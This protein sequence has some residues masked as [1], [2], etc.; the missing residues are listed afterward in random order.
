VAERTVSR[1]F[2][3]PLLAVVAAVFLWSGIAPRDRFTW[4][5]E[6]LP[7]LVAA[8]LLA[9][10][11]RRFRLTPLAYTL[12]AG[13]AII[14]MVGGH[15]T[16]AQVPLFNWLRDA[17]GLTRNHFDRV[18]H[19]AQGFVP[20]I[21]A[22]EVLLRRTPLRPGG[23]LF[24]IVTAICLSISALYELFEW[25]VAETTGTAADAFL[26]TQGDFWDTQKDMMMCLIGA[27]FALALLSRAHDR[28]LARLAGSISPVVEKS[29]SA[30]AGS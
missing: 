27:V 8:P 25:G 10:I 20:A 1:G 2:E 28:T 3:L 21:V 30:A 18:G 22:R 29:K 19:F 17:L 14:L 6:V 9:L 13:H 11:W 4:F 23:W 24:T 12:I 5:L 7:V 26:G 15:Y 16:Y